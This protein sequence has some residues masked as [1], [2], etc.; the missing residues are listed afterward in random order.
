MKYRG[1]IIEESL[2]D[3]RT[4][5]NITII[6]MHISTQENKMDRWHLLEVEIEDENI[7][8]LSKEIIEGWYAHFWHGTDIIVIF[9]DKIIKFNYL[10]KKSWN[11]V[12]EYGNK[13]GIP[14]EQLDFPIF[15]I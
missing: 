12:L 11:E 10:D 15:G 5:N 6:K 1:I 7:E 8:K 2:V 3:N 9:K 13:L 14:N 4:L